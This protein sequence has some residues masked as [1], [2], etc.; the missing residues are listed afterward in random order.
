MMSRWTGRRR[1]C[2]VW[3]RLAEPWA[4]RGTR[5]APN[6]GS[7]VP[8]TQVLWNYVFLLWAQPVESSEPRQQVRRWGSACSLRS[9]SLNLRSCVPGAGGIRC[10]RIR[11]I[12]PKETRVLSYAQPE[13]QW[14]SRP[15]TSSYGATH[16]SCVHRVASAPRRPNPPPVA[17]WT[18]TSASSRKAARACDA[19]SARQAKPRI[20]QTGQA[21]GLPAGLPLFVACVGIAG[22][23]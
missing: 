10:I 1:P 19:L 6:P 21:E 12:R 3:S 5:T 8:R 16:I 2:S 14:K 15:M 9:L 4:V 22:W 13:N 7:P 20:C 11:P 18:H 23:P 17:T